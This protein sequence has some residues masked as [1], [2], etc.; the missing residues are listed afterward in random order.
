MNQGLGFT[1]GWSLDFNKNE[2]LMKSDKVIAFLLGAVVALCSAVVVLVVTD[3]AQPAYAVEAG[4]GDLFGMVGVGYQG[5]SRDVL[6]LIDASSKR[7]AVYDYKNERIRLTNVRN[8]KWDMKFEEFPGRTQ[9]PSVEKQ[10]KAILDA[11]KKKGRN[12]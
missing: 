3:R 9:K 1:K 2:D 11:E 12:G 6:F 4:R 5:Q 7:I 8:V 10:R